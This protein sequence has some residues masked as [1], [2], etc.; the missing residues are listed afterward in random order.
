MLPYIIAGCLFAS[1]FIESIFGFGGSILGVALV[2]NFIDIKQGILIVTFASMIC[3]SFVLLSD[4]KNFSLRDIFEIFKFALP[5]IFLGT[6]LLTVLNSTLLLKFF[7]VFLLAY[8]LYSLAKAELK[9]PRWLCRFV[10]F[11]GGVVQGI[12][13][14]GGP[15]VLMGYGGEFAH[16]SHTRATMAG[17]FLLA[18]VIRVVQLILMGEF[19]FSVPV[20]YWWLAGP[21]AAA[22]F[23]GYV[24]HK[25]IDDRFFKR[26]ILV[27]MFIAGV[28]YLLK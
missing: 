15:F 8:S 18:N 13:A 1:Y 6:F 3:S 16:K 23:G 28:F 20:N 5:G 9:F 21:I 19:D 27:L 17:F 25:R 14:T 11:C 24:V 2:G 12:Y 26:G 22:V 4:F 7:A 10:L